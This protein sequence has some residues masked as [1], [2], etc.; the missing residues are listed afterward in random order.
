MKKLL[1]FA[2]TAIAEILV[3]SDLAIL[4][5]SMDLNCSKRFEQNSSGA[6]TIRYDEQEKA[7]RF[8]VKFSPGTDFWCYPRL[9]LQSHESLANA[10]AIRFEFRAEQKNA[11]TGYKCA[12][13]MFEKERPY[14]KLPKPKPEYQSV[15]I[16]LAKAV[17]NPAAIRQL[18]IGMNPL[19]DKLTFFIRNIEVLGNP[20]KQPPCQ[21]AEAIVVHA[22]VSSQI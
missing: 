7:I 11:D 20:E 16:D 18:Q 22:L 19:S 21:T 3:A 8:D 9:R 5:W 13:V 4:P 2:I 14:F 17:K 6:M 15:T 10:D 12:Y 1:F